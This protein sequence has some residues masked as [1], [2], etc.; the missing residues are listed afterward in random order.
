MEKSISTS[1]EIS[2]LHKSIIKVIALNISKRK[3]NVIKPPFG[4]EKPTLTILQT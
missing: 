4:R 1:I 3:Y 2:K